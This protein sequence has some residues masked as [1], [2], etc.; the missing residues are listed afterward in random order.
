MKEISSNLPYGEFIHKM[1]KLISKGRLAGIINFIHQEETLIIEFIKF[2]S[3]KIF[4]KLNLLDKGFIAYYEKESITF[5]HSIFRNEIEIYL[6]DLIK[7]MG[8]VV[9]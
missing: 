9:K 2:G 1:Q 8:A 6:V 4:Y 7:K 5:T 3:S